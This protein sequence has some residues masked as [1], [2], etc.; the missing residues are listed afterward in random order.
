MGSI[1]QTITTPTVGERTSAQLTLQLTDQDDVELL[2]GDL[3][4]VTLTLYEKRSG[5]ILNSRNGVSIFNNNGGAISSA[6][7]LTLV[8]SNAD[9]ALLSQ[10]AKEEQHVALIRWTWL[11]GQRSGW[12][13]I[14]FP[15]V[16]QLKV[17]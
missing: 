12:K 15:V 8:L 10:A 9:N 4:T 3:S 13:E 1:Q 2:A 7:V 17:T 6:G 11:S 5:T 14:S 16:N